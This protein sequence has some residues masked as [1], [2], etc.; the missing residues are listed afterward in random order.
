MKKKQI[1]YGMLG[2]LIVG[3]LVTCSS[4]AASPNEPASLLPTVT[5]NEENNSVYENESIS[6]THVEVT[7][8]G[9]EKTNVGCVNVVEE[10]VSYSIYEPFGLHFNEDK[11]ELIFENEVVRYFYDGV[12]IST[13]EAIV[14]CDYLNIKG[15]V[16]VYT[17]RKPIDNEDGSIDPFGELTGIERYSQEE[18]AQRDLSKFHDFSD[19][20][21]CAS[22]NDDPAARTFTERFGVY[23]EFGI[24]YVEAQDTSGIGNVYYNGQLVNTFID[25]SPNGGAFTFRSADGG[26]IDVQTVYGT[27]GNLTGVEQTN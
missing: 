21:T 18:F 25:N 19:E 13:Q 4:Q 1:F 9:I 20:V 7:T 22:G 26:K 6:G 24:E 2:L 17:T 3:C 23:K 16:D 8:A 15:T 11:N 12:N 27:N 5:G 14:Y 10:P